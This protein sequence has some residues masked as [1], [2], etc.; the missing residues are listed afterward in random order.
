MNQEKKFTA[1]QMD[2]FH[3]RMKQLQQRRVLGVLCSLL[4][5]MCILFGLLGQNNYEHWYYSI[6]ATFYANSN[7][8]MIGL[9][10]ATAVFFISYKG[11]NTLDRV[12]TNLSAIFALGVVVFPCH[13]EGGPDHAG[14]FYLPIGLSNVLHFICAASLFLSFAVMILCQFTKG[15]SNT[16]RKRARNRVYRICGWGIIVVLVFQASSMLLGLPGWLTMVDEF[17]MLQ[18]FAMAWLTKGETFK[19]LND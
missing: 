15:K 8:C 18:F 11:Y 4:A 1:K 14:L 13:V 10:F 16:P 9:L 19:R 7:M 17:L 2:E 3:S 12:L 6:S 5:P